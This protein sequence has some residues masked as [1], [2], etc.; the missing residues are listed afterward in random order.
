MPPSSPAVSHAANFDRIARPYRWLEYLSF[1]PM[2][3]RSRFCRIPQL[4]YA[5]RALVLGDGDGRFLARL[6]ACDPLLHADVVDQSPA[7][8]RILQSR[9][10]SVHARDRIQIHLTDARTFTPTGTYDL[11]VAHFFLDCFTTD[12][13]QSLAENIRPHLSPDA[14]WLISEFAIPDGIASLPAKSIV[15]ALYIAFRLITGLRTRTLPDHTT[16][17]TSS[18]FL[19][20]DRR[21]ILFGLLVSELWS[22]DK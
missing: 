22:I 9:A 21:L 13:V 20:Q 4:A 5:R 14:I 19:L 17:L 6:L 10:D 7:M 1:G 12:E 2:L 18:G 3:E 11:V 15:S 8:L 16:A